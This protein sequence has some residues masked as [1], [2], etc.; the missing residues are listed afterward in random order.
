MLLLLFLTRGDF[1]RLLIGRLFGRNFQLK[2]VLDTEHK[3]S[4]D[5]YIFFRIRD[6]VDRVI[7]RII[8]CNS[9]KM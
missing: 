6:I 8:L 7:A 9:N 2:Y 5:I 1:R 4:Y 3:F